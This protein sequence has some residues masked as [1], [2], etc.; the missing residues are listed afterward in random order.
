MSREACSHIPWLVVP[1]PLKTRKLGPAPHFQTQP[2]S[3]ASLKRSYPAREASRD[4]KISC[5]HVWLKWCNIWPPWIWQ[6]HW[7]LQVV[8]FFLHFCT[9]ESTLREVGINFFPP[10][11]HLGGAPNQP[12]PKP[13]EKPFLNWQQLFKNL[14]KLI[15]LLDR[16]HLVSG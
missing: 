2:L 16:T 6:D 13:F 9:W 4:I 8:M 7:S 15:K 3:L 5:W 14:I 10:A 12:N 1:F 11:S